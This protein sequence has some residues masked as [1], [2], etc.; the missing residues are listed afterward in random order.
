MT[1]LTQ[2]RSQHVKTLAM[3]A[4][5]LIAVSLLSGLMRDDNGPRS[6]RMGDPVLPGFNEIRS[7]ASEIRVTVADEAY[8]LVNSEAGWRMGDD[9]GYPIRADRLAALAS[10]LETLTWGAGRTQD[11]EKFNRVGLGD[12]RGGGTGALLQIVDRSGEVSAELITG[13][14][15]PHIYARAPDDT[16]A[17]RVTG[18]LPPLFTHDAWL[19]LDIIDINAD[20]ISAIRL[21]DTTGASLFLQ[22]AV[23]GSER[24]FRPGPPYQDYRLVSRIAASTPALALTRLQPIGVKPSDELKTQEAARHITQTYDGLEVDLRAYREADGYYVTLRAIEA[25]EGARRGSTINQK[26]EGWAFKISEYDWSDFTPRVSSIV[27]PQPETVV[28]PTPVPTPGQ[29]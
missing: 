18:D 27:R 20:A 4:G 22:R 12:P 19:D 24:S 29:P 7:E 2:K 26:A 11:P 17:Y 3:V 10:G 9:E 21:F 23:G 28:S 6:D 5:G 16:Q 8:T 14:K 1:L 25:G 13:R 15:G